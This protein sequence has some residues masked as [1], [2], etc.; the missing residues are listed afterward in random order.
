M[1]NFQKVF[2]TI[3]SIL[4]LIG[5][6]L[7][8]YNNYE[9]K[10]IE[11]YTGFRGEAKTNQLFAARV[12]LKRMGIPAEKKD[13]L[14]NFPSTDSVILIDTERATLPQKTLNELM[15]WVNKGGHLIIRART[16]GIDMGIEGDDDEYTNDSKAK[17]NKTSP[18]KQLT[19]F[20]PDLFEKTLGISLF[21]SIILEEAELPIKVKLPER[22][23]ALNLDLDFFYPMKSSN[24]ADYQQAYKKKIFWHE[25]IIG[26]GRISLLA[27]LDFLTNSALDKQDHAELFWYLV[28][29]QH[30]QPKS[31]WLINQDD[32]PPL[33]QLLWKYG[34]PFVVCIL[35]LIPLSIWAYSPRFG[36]LQPTPPPHRRRI[37][38]HIEASG[39]FMWKRFTQQHD[40]NY[41]T[42][43]DAVKQLSR[44]RNSNDL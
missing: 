5:G 6:T 34:W 40:T 13:S 22:N 43:A 32:M 1:N 23:Q 38:E 21:S 29:R 8:F 27:N 17:K 39:L 33:W 9:L 41:A 31:V 4:L 19:Y 7:W 36:P 37:L 42:F 18:E 3:I 2:F 44:S 15:Q 24:K 28:H 14:F 20:K 35:L 10:E 16:S 12:F 11:K 30:E 25:Q 26:N